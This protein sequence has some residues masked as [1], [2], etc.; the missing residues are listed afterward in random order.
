MTLNLAMWS[1]CQSLTADSQVRSRSSPSENFGVSN[2]TGGGG[3]NFL[4]SSYFGQSTSAPHSSLNTNPQQT[5]K[6]ASPEKL[7]R[8]VSSDTARAAVK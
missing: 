8:T 7:Q 3:Q 6:Q 4:M 1:S 2:D 5:E